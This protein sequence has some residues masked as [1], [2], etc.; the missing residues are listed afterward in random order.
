MAIKVHIEEAIKKLQIEKE[1]AVVSVKERVTR[2]QIVPF[3]M[4]ID[5]ARD[6]AIAQRNEEL[7]EDIKA[8][9]EAFALERQSFIESAE[10]K[11]ADNAKT[12]LETETAIV[13]AEYDKHIE[14][15]RELLKEVNE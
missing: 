6:S 12:L 9:Q 11:K 2:E 8:R 14:R 13:A 4:E 5:K 15:L 3:N 10:K 1:R 7:N